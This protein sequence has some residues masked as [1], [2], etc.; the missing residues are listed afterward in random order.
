MR[1]PALLGFCALLGLVYALPTEPTCAVL[2]VASGYQKVNC[3][4]L[5]DMRCIC[6]QSVSNQ[7]VEAAQKCMQTCPLEEQDDFVM[8]VLHDVCGQS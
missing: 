6:P 8:T 1:S 7:Y 3:V 5:N 4:F 2:C